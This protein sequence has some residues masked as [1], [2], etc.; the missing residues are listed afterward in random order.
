MHILHRIRTTA[1][2]TGS[3][4]RKWIL[5]QK[6]VV[7]I[8]SYKVSSSNPRHST[9]GAPMLRSKSADDL[10]RARGLY[11]HFGLRTIALKLLR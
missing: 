7:R 9:S 8:I 3:W 10:E 2:A 6:H 11:C 4:N 1:T 5:Y